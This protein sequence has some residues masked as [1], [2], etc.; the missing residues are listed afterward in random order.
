[1]HG[2]GVNKLEMR[3]QILKLFKDVDLVLFNQNLAFPRLAFATRWKVW[4]IC[5]SAHY[6][7]GKNKQDKT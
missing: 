3:V 6:A 7:T 4:L 2:G 5:S 1:M